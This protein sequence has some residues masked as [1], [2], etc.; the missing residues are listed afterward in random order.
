MPT[1]ELFDLA[2]H[3]IKK[4]AQR[5]QLGA[6][7]DGRGS[8]RDERPAAASV[9]RSSGR[10]GRLVATLVEVNAWSAA[11]CPFARAPSP[12]RRSASRRWARWPSSR[13]RRRSASSWRATLTQSVRCDRPLLGARPHQPARPLRSRWRRGGPWSTSRVARGRRRLPR[14][15]REPRAGG[16]GRRAEALARLGARRRLLPARDGAPR[17]V[18]PARLPYAG[19]DGLAF[20]ITLPAR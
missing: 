19:D 4:R 20:E 12:G 10:I 18:D 3:D 5:R 15:R 16:A 1:D 9:R 7:H 6:R 2:A 14:P 11:R 17:R 13:R 8:G